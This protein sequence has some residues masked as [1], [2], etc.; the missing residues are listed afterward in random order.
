MPFNWSIYSIPFKII[1]ERYG[2]SA[3]ILKNG[4]LAVWI[5]KWQPTP[6]FLP[7]ESHGQRRLVGY[8]PRGRKESD[9]T[10]RLHFTSL[11]LL[12]IWLY[13]PAGNN[14]F[15]LASTSQIRHEFLSLANTSLEPYVEEDSRKYS[16]YP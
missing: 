3:T 5:R 2:F 12:H 8:S 13:L 4:F 14:A 7:G 16:S 1:I 6:I 15:L 9:L 10:E 11:V